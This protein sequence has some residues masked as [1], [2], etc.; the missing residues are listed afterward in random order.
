[1]NDLKNTSITFSFDGMD[2]LFRAHGHTLHDVGMLRAGE[3]LRIPDVVVW[4]GDTEFS[5]R[6]MCGF[7]LIIIFQTTIECHNHVE[8]IMTLASKHNVAIV[9]IGGGTNVTG[10]VDCSPDEKRTIVSLDTSQM[11]SSL[12]LNGIYSFV[13]FILLFLLF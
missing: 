6:G 10:A 11:V 3:F 4:P 13:S 8:E 7:S 12:F 5:K 9:P 1:M 2:R